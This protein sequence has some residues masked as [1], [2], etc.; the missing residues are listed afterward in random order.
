MAAA[1]HTIAKRDPKQYYFL[2]RTKDN[3]ADRIHVNTGPLQTTQQIYVNHSDYGTY[4]QRQ[5]SNV[6]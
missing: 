4:K 1:I 6:E 5:L 3:V 2:T